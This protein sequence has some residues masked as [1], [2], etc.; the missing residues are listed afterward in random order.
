[1][2]SIN[3]NTDIS[4]FLEKKRGQ[5]TLTEQARDLNVQLSFLSHVNA[6]RK[7]ASKKMINRMKEFYNLSEAEIMEVK[8]MSIRKED[9]QEAEYIL[10]SNM[11]AEE[12]AVYLRYGK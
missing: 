2:A 9:L 3:V 10:Q 8:K 5:K 4:I 12:L 6:G 1:M 7:P 11:T